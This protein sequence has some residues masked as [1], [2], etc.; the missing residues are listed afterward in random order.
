M[1]IVILLSSKLLSSYQIMMTTNSRTSATFV[2]TARRTVNM[3]SVITFEE[4]DCN[5]INK[6][7]ENS[8]KQP[9]EKATLFK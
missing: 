3:M 1:F 4:R 2:V 5:V 6:A 9:V 7:E 8:L